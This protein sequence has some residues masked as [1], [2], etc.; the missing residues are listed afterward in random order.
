M[1]KNKTKNRF[2]LSEKLIIT[3]KIIKG[4]NIKSKFTEMFNMLLN[5]SFSTKFEFTNK[6]DKSIAK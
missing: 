2:L 6:L 5:I 4:S 3:A 1:H